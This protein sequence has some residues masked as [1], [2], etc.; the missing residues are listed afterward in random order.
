MGTPPTPA[1]SDQ[2]TAKRAYLRADV[3]RR[4]LLAAAERLIA[5]E[6]LRGVTMVALAAE[7]GVSRQLV[8]DHFADVAD[9]YDAF[10]DAQV[11]TYAE[12]VDRVIGEADGR[13]PAMAVFRYLLDLPA[14]DQ[15]VVR[16]LV[17]DPGLPEVQRARERFRRRIVE[18]WSTLLP[19]REPEAAAALV[20][21]VLGSFLAL[22]D[23]V[24]RGELGRA[25]AEDAAA[26]ILGGLRQ[27]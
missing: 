20:W 9:V 7:A 21:A 16:A 19:D 11:T 13:R 27:V 12:A 22:A 17:V 6:G 8:Y 18:K 24:A 1:R 15:Q 10:Y 25:T 14:D 4:Q 2:L 26:A 5:R 23:L 3:R